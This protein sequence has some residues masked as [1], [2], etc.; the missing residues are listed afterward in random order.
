MTTHPW[1]NLPIGEV[2]VQLD[3]TVDANPQLDVVNPHGKGVAI[4][5]RAL[6]RI[7]FLPVQASDQWTHQTVAVPILYL[8]TIHSYLASPTSPTVHFTILKDCW[9]GVWISMRGA[10]L[11]ELLLSISVAV[12]GYALRWHRHYPRCHTP[13][14]LIS[15]QW[16]EYISQAIVTQPHIVGMQAACTHPRSSVRTL[17][18]ISQW[19]SF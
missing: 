10:V 18:A 19:F 11:K 1:S 17:L 7:K 3:I 2:I 16:E 12:V 9:A 14:S 13:A 6:S 5:N 8:D 4:S 15:K